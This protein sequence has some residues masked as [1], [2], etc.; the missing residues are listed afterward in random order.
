MNSALINIIRKKAVDKNPLIHCITNPIS[1]NQCANGVLA[2]GARPMMAEHPQEVAEITQAADALVI[3]LAN[4]TDVRM[5][6]MKISA[7]TAQKKGIPFI[8]DAVGV[9]CSALRRSFVNDF[10][11]LFKPTAIKGNYSEIYALYDDK[12]TSAG[13]DADETL[14]LENISKTA[15][16]LAQKYS[17]MVL[18]SGKTDIVT[19][20]KTVVYINNGVPQLAQITGTGCLLGVL[21]G[22]YLSVD[23]TIN[24]LVTACAVLGICGELSQTDKGNGSFFVNLMDNLSVL[25]DSQIDELLKIEVKANEEL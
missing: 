6:S 15:V 9:A 11:K 7:Q 16:K 3:N 4:I 22:C 23:Q 13:V 24:S 18:A 5:Q 8:I 14:K 25:K 1:I 20:G 12:Y 2:V 21:C 17:T 10:L 19:D